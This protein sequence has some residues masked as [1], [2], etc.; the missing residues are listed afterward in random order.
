MKNTYNQVIIQ[1]QVTICK[2]IKNEIIMI[3]CRVFNE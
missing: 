2:Q 1:Y 3:I